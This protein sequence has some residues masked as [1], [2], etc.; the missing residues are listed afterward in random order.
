MTTPTSGIHHITAVASGP[1]K[2]L[3]FY[4]STLG[5]QL[6][7]RTVNFDDPATYHL[8]FGDAAGSPGTILTFFPWPGAK[9]GTR[10]AGVVSATTFAV[11]LGSLNVWST[12]LKSLG[13]KEISGATRFGTRV[14]QFE[15]H[16]GTQLELAESAARSSNLPKALDASIAITGFHSAT[17]TVRDLDGTMRMMKDHLGMK[18]AA[19][20]GNR[21][22]LIAG[23]GTAIGSIVDLVHEPQTPIAHLGA[24]IVHHIAMRVNGDAHQQELQNKLMDAGFGVTDVRERMY[25]RSVYYRE[26]S[27]VLFE[28]ATDSPGFLID[29]NPDTLGSS[30]KLPPQ[31]EEMRSKIEARLPVLNTR[32]AVKV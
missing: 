25:F 9:R 7:K 27:G 14:I 11:P 2:N 18:V 24:G 10:G 22:R 20:E 17:L 13:V 19:N 1:Q 29:E 26:R 8:Y 12:R 28:L 21:T 16:D 32:Q 4:V 23:N 3:D 31:Y 6:A 5:L 15:D 30:L